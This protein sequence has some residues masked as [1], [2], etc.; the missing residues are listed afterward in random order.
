MTCSVGLAVW[1]FR[2]SALE[3]IGRADQ[4]LYT[5]KAEGRNCCVTA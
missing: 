4:A 2:E 3:L 1:D 5:A